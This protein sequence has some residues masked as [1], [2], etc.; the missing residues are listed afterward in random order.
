MHK[1]M[2]TFADNG[3]RTIKCRYLL[4]YYVKFTQIFRL[5]YIK[6]R[7]S[8]NPARLGWVWFQMRKEETF[9]KLFFLK[10]VGIFRKIFQESRYG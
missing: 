3:R 2:P 4:L 6:V 10:R 8:H 1:M 5:N 9:E 7:F